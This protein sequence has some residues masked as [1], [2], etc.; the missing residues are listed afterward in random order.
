MFAFLTP[1]PTPQP[2]NNTIIFNQV[3]LVRFSGI[4]KHVGF[5]KKIKLEI[6]P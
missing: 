5:L 6:L 4:K 3:S 1:L 2:G